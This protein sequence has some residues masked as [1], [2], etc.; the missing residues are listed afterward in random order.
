LALQ[1]AQVM[2]RRPLPD[3]SAMV[4][5]GWDLLKILF[6]WMMSTAIV[7]TAALILGIYVIRDHIKEVLASAPD[8]VWG[9]PGAFWE[10]L[11][12]DLG[13]PGLRSPEVLLIVTSLAFLL[14]SVKYLREAS[15][16][17]DD[18]DIFRTGGGVRRDG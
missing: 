9:Y 2:L 13:R 16:R 18:K 14:V 12:I 3:F 7:S 17:L 6:R 1:Q 15:Y 11:K 5:K 10:V 8:T 4:S